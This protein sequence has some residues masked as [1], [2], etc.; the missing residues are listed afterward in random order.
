MWVVYVTDP[1]WQAECSSRVL[2]FW[3]LRPESREAHDIMVVSLSLQKVAPALVALAEEPPLGR[4]RPQFSSNIM[5]VVSVLNF[6]HA[7][8]L[9]NVGTACRSPEDA[10]TLVV[11]AWWWWSLRMLCF[12]FW[13][14]P[15]HCWTTDSNVSRA[16]LN[17]GFSWA[18]GWGPPSPCMDS[19]PFSHISSA[20]SSS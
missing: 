2:L 18:V 15:V 6:D 12:D 19:W 8:F 20:T 11:G 14:W 13:C 4:R 16:L 1:E 17:V 7:L 3:K 5:L 10:A 9:D